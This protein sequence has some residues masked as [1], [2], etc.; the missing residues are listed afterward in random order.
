[1]LPP[2]PE[3]V[4]L[5][6]ALAFGG[7]FLVLTPPFQVCDE[8]AHFRHAFAVSE[9]HCLAVV[10][11]SESGDEQPRSLKTL[12]TLYAPLCLH[13]EQKTTAATIVGQMS[14]PLD[15]G[16]RVFSSYSSSA[17]CSPLP[18]LPQALG[19]FLARCFS[20]SALICFNA[21]RLLNWLVATLLTFVAIRI[22][23]VGKAGFA[24][25][26]LLPMSLSLNASFS[27]DALTN[28]IS[29]LFVAHVLA[30]AAG[31]DERVSLESLAVAALLGAALGL[32][33]Q[34]YVLLPL[35]Y[36]LIPVRKLGT[37]RAYLA[38]FTLVAGAFLV[39][40]VGWGFVVRHSLA[41]LDPRL[42][43]DPAKQL[44]WI[45]S[46]PREFCQTLL[47]T[48]AFTRVIAEG[49]VGSLGYANLRL[50]G[51]LYVAELVVLVTAFAGDRE[52]AA[53][54]T[55]RQALLAAA[56][57]LLVGLS[58]VFAAYV[59]WNQV[60]AGIIDGLQGRYFIPIVPL[61]GIFVG[62]TCGP[63]MRTWRPASGAGTAVVA[64]T[65]PVL[66]SFA[67]L[68]VY[69]RFFVDSAADAARRHSSRGEV[70][71]HEGH[72]QQAIEE[73]EAALRID[74]NHLTSR[75]WLG[76]LL[77]ETRPLEATEHYRA[78]VRLDPGSTDAL[79]RL[80]DLLVRRGDFAEAMSCF[81]E[82][83]R[84]DPQSAD[85]KRDI[86]NARRAQKDQ[87][88]ALQSVGQIC[89]AAARTTGSSES[90]HRGTARA[91]DYLKPNRGR[92]V[93]AD[94][95]NP[96]GPLEF[97]W[98]SPPPAGGE[99]LLSGQ[100]GATPAEGRRRAFYACS[101]QPIRGKRVFV[102]PLPA[103]ARALADED[104]S[105][106]YQVPLADLNEVE[107]VQ[108]GE[109]RHQHGLRFPLTALPE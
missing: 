15:P 37:V 83:Q 29:F 75:M 42:G 44:R 108:E 1:M 6:L 21:G 74:P 99:S 82:A 89:L 31:R 38:G 84:L 61:I 14:I 97:F 23:P 76:Y 98:R 27:P 39:A 11:G 26:A 105:W 102:F 19:V 24:A 25:L 103:G 66:L 80:A 104:V 59:A 71:E 78:A 64:L 87:E 92:I 45:G 48:A 70:L 94:G 60:G 54:V 100:E 41:P 35:C 101:A 68:R 93:G 2:K 22:T 43:V 17:I 36:F 109:Y 69:D 62:R 16:D 90:R 10:R 88:A 28:A 47:R 81:Q 58:V 46:H 4:Y 50:Q 63:V 52:L 13:P 9:G 49:C 8:E 5:S 55:V 56:V 18:Y 72:R 67:L 77:S 96:F 73:F 65:V 107:R 34:G 7:A 53:R 79:Q 20:S 3:W 32:S 57:A 85:L 95:N 106:F 91:G 40:A 12:A 30:C 86:E 51:W 33:K